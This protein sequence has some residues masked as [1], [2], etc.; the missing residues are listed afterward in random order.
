MSVPAAL[1][2]YLRVCER[3]CDPLPTP[4]PQPSGK[5]SGQPVAVPCPRG[6]KWGC[7]HRGDPGQSAPTHELAHGRQPRGQGIE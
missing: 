6:G 5:P 3:L 4:V 1:G 7:A 2:W